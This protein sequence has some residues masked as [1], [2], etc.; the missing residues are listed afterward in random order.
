MAAFTAAG[1]A[2]PLAHDQE[3]TARVLRG[4]TGVEAPRL[5]IR[6]ARADGLLRIEVV[7]DGVGGADPA[8]GTGLSGVERRLAAFDGI[9]AV[10]SPPGGP[11]IVIMEV[12]C[13]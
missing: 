6:M 4:R 2:M 1:V 5:Q 9:L 3:A 7:D 11:T 10:S 12:P 13:A 8:G